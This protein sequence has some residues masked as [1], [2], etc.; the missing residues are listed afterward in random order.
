VWSL[1]WACLEENPGSVASGGW[2]FAETFEEG[3]RAHGP[4]EV[5]GGVFSVPSRGHGRAPVHVHGS[6][7]GE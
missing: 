6:R 1:R 3:G 5:L 7:R 2:N 4:G